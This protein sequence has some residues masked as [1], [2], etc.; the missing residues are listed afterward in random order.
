MISAESD[1][2]LYTQPEDTGHV[3]STVV[4]PLETIS[5]GLK[6]SLNVFGLNTPSGLIQKSGLLGSARNS[7]LILWNYRN[8]C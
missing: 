1:F 3:F 4:C 5:E 7:A 2:F 8:N 6:L